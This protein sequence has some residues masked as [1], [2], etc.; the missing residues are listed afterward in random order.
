MDVKR[1][2][3]FGRTA[4][5]LLAVRGCVSSIAFA[6][7][8]IKNSPAASS[9]SDDDDQS[10]LLKMKDHECRDA[11]EIAVDQGHVNFAAMLI[12]CGAPHEP[13]FLKAKYDAQNVE[14]MKLKWKP[15]SDAVIC[16]KNEHG[17]LQHRF[18]RTLFRGSL[19]YA[20]EENPLES[21]PD[22]LAIFNEKFS[23]F[24]LPTLER[25]QTQNPAFAHL[26]HTLAFTR[27]P[28]YCHVAAEAKQGLSV[29]IELT[30]PALSMRQTTLHLNEHRQMAPHWLKRR[31]A[32]PF[33]RGFWLWLHTSLTVNATL[34]PPN[35]F[36]RN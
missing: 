33:T 11:L 8:L 32:W 5:H 17:S 16:F 3:S 24:S 27:M 14:G 9:N 22:V 19:T 20:K 12:S 21:D 6:E 2:D 18:L 28:G 34:T 26:V 4:L 23:P 35:R 13:D 15:V 7:V 29:Y 36:L 31:A 25:A 10:D 1:R 30:A